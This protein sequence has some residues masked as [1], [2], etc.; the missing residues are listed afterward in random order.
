[1]YLFTMEIGDPS[2][3]G[4]G[5][6]DT[7]IY[8]S[9]HPMDE[10]L[11]V[12]KESCL[13]LGITLGRETPGE[14]LF[15]EYEQSYIPGEVYERLREHDCPLAFERWYEDLDRYYLEDDLSSFVEWLIKL[16]NPE[17]ELTEVKLE[18]LNPRGWGYG[19]FSE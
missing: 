11:E 14:E 12:Y 10:V 18:R 19:M 17:I 4:H 6:T 2:R 1:M 15:N 3:D 5:M 13:K 9:S 16:S 7:F 8:E